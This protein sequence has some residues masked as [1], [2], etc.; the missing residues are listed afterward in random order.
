MGM[1]MPVA[2]IRPRFGAPPAADR[3]MT[4]IRQLRSPNCGP[5][6]DN[7]LPRYVV[8]HYTAMPTA[9]DAIKRLCDA[10]AEVSSHYVICK[11]GEITQLVSEGLR[12]WHA[13]AGEWQGLQDI[14]SRSIGIELDN[15]GQSPFTDALM[16]SLTW[17]LARILAGWDIPP[18]HVIGHSDLAPGRKFDPGPFF[19]WP[20]LERTGL[21]AAG[22]TTSAPLSADAEQFRK[23]AQA[24]GYT[25]CVDDSDLLN[26][27]RLRYR[28]TASGPLEAADFVPL[29]PTSPVT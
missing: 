20:A 18:S 27:I 28:P 8:L 19:D 17:L 7:L 2:G 14:N 6:R 13:G 21:A 24:R 29:C 5:R 12:A 16:N 10:E 1:D 15:D 22:G 25:A 9:Q 4:A 26:A 23:L 11:S 3:R